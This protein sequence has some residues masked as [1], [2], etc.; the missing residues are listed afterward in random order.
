[1]AYKEPN[2]IRKPMSEEAKARIAEAVRIAAAKK[3][4]ENGVFE[5]AP[6]D[7]FTNRDIELVKMSDQEFPEELF[8]TMETGKPVDLMF[9]EDGGVPKA[10]NYMMIGDPGVGKSTVSLDILSDLC[11]EG[12]RVLFISAEMTRIDLHGYVK[13]F[14]K[15]GDVDTLFLSEYLDADPKKVIEKVLEPGYD[16]VLLDSFAEIQAHLKESL[17]IN[18]NS[19]EKWITNTMLK[20]NSGSNNTKT[21]TTFIAIQQVTKEGVQLGTNRLKHA[22][23]GMIELRQDKESGGSYIEFTKNRRGTVNIKMYYTLSVTGDVRY[24]LDRFSKAVDGV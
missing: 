4:L 18:S 6:N 23:T 11:L 20:H 12:Y 2:G 13:R 9:T 21:Y 15:F 7:K 14:P 8:E 10:C 24:D 17:G 5:S 3:R 19:A 1:M 22:M 16:V